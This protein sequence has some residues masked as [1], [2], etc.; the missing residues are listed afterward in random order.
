M[1]KW[2]GEQDLQG[3]PE[4]TEDDVREALSICVRRIESNVEKYGAGFFGPNSL[5]NFY[6]AGENRGWT[7]GFHTGQ[8]W[9]SYENEDDPT[10]KEKIKETAEKQVASFLYRIETLNDVDHHDM[11]FLYS[12][13]CV[14]AWKLYQ[15][16]DGKKAALLAADQLIR[17]FQEK[18]AF[19]QAWGAMGEPENYRFI[20]DCLLNL[21]LLYWASEET[22]DP[23]YKE[24]AERHIHTAMG[25]VIREDDSCWHTV[26]MN[27]ETGL[28]DHGATC[29][30]YQDGS[31]WARGQAWGIYGTAVA[32]RYTKREEYFT[33]F[34][35]VTSY[36]LNHLPKDLIP[37]WDLTFGDGD[38]LPFTDERVKNP[39]E[40]KSL[41]ENAFEPRDSSSA[42]IAACGMLEMA[43]YLNEKDADYY[44]GIA[45]KLLK[46]VLDTCF[47]KEDAKTNGILLHGTYSHHSPFNTCTPEGT[48]ECV[49]WGDYNFMEALN[50]LHQPQWQIYL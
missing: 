17:R 42:V 18:G 49:I 44:T 12:P 33:Y 36:F 34:K 38:G 8:Y 41:Y 35:R 1:S 10:R 26:F 15:N 27:P 13:S 50:R 21:P 47:E 11:G 28:F 48:D 16:E 30:G 37:Y 23:K 45:K 5:G 2:I 40:D 29:Q 22:G 20:I 4:I 31:A 14:A 19:L 24:I 39:V 43:K 25:N 9:L 3:Y 32:Y 6:R 46:A 7:T